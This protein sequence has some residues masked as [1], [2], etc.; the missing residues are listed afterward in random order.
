MPL[1]AGWPGPAGRGGAAPWGEVGWKE[2]VSSSEERGQRRSGDGRGCFGCR[3][4]HVTN[5]HHLLLLV[6]VFS[7]PP[8]TQPGPA[9]RSS[10]ASR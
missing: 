5:D 8:P 9:P 10:G 3:H 2:T 4:Q 1:D 7:S 6:T